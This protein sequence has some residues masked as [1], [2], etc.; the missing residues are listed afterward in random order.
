MMEVSKTDLPN[1]STR[2]YQS[3]RCRLGNPADKTEMSAETSKDNCCV[4]KVDIQAAT[5]ST[6]D[7]EVK[8]TPTTGKSIC[9]R[10]SCGLCASIFRPSHYCQ[11]PPGNKL[12]PSQSYVT[13]IAT[14]IL[15]SAEMRM[16]LGSIYE[17][18]EKKY[19]YFRGT[20]VAPGYDWQEAL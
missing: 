15:D 14:A 1:S 12:K 10:K 11:L 9:K 2:Y 8:D 16:S 13:M 20:Q 18:I 4:E 5:S 19:P 6:Q 7:S 3:Q 17:W